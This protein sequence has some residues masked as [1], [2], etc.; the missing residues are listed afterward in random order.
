VYVGTR[1]TSWRVRR[2][3]AGRTRAHLAL[4]LASYVYL[5]GNNPRVCANFNPGNDGFGSCATDASCGGTVGACKP[6]PACPRCLASATSPTGNLCFSGKHHGQPCTPVGSKLT[7]ID[8]PPRDS[9]FLAPLNVTLA[10]L[11]TGSTTLTA[12]T[13][14]RFC[15]VVG[16]ESCVPNPSGP[17]GGDTCQT[18]PGAFGKTTARRIEEAG[19]PAGP[20]IDGVTGADLPGPGAVSIRGTFQTLP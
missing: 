1:P 14:G 19:V 8:C 11:G 20:P 13:N 4:P 18:H 12:A 16:K 17:V 2:I 9:T 5:T 6:P 7:T 10:P 3:K 15:P